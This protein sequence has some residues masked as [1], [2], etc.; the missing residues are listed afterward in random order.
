MW[1]PVV[2][3]LTGTACTSLSN[4]IVCFSMLSMYAV[5]V[6]VV[7]SLSSLSYTSKDMSSSSPT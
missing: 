1:F 7:T 2:R 4:D 6:P 3:L 5:T